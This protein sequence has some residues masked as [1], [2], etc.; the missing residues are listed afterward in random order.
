MTALPPPADDHAPP[1]AAPSPPAS[2]LEKPWL[3]A[4]VVIGLGTLARLPQLA[5]SLNGSHSFRQSQTALVAR[6]Y[7]E[8]GIDLLHTPLTVFGKNSDVPME[9]PLVQAVAALFVRLGLDAD[10]AMR[11][12]GLIAFQASALMLFALLRR[13]HGPRIAVIAVVVLE[14]A[15]FT[16]LWAAASLIEFAA[17]ALALAMV[18]SLDRW[19]TGGR[20]WWLAVGVTGAWL[21]FLVKPTT[22]PPYALLLAGSGVAVLIQQ[23]WR[24]SWGRVVLGG[25][26]AILP[27]LALAAA[28]TSYADRIKSANP[29]T[30][31]LTSSALENWNFGTVAQR[32]EVANYAVIMDR[33]ADGIAGRYAL[34]LFAGAAAILLGLGLVDR[35]RRIA[36]AGAAALGP[37]LFFN[38][39][40]VHS[41][42]LCA[43]VPAIAALAAL[44]LDGVARVAQRIGVAPGPRRQAAV[45]AAATALV[46]ASTAVSPLGRKDLQEW[47]TD[48]PAPAGAAILTAHTEPGS[49]V[50]LIGCDWNPQLPFLAHRDAVMFAPWLSDGRQY[51][52]IATDAGDYG[53]LY[54]CHD[55]DP[56]PYLPPGAT[57]TPS[58]RPGLWQVNNPR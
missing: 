9:F 47:R 15:P 22:T 8:R 23:G 38:L 31:F 57:A 52:D 17:V 51:W 41:Y 54:A 28:W 53:W 50:I 37:L 44:G 30:V 2:M 21:A 4:G 48:T 26:A 43:V 25:A 40:L 14:F 33:I 32:S 19:F 29:M 11:L 55:G 7:A 46:L 24:R 27:G 56:L 42:Y 39:Y 13:W 3:L 12:V 20:W 18:L 49:K 35:V 45:A 6:N 1:A 10:M 5:H 36:W 16:M 34:S 58:G